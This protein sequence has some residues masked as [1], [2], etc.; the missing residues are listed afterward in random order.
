MK[1]YFR[2]RRSEMKYPNRVQ[3]LRQS[4]GLSRAEVAQQVGITPQALGLI[5][6]GRV[7]PLTHV[8]LGLAQALGTTVESLFQQPEAEQSTWRLFAPDL[9][10]ARV[11][12]RIRAVVGHVSGQPI[13]R[14][15]QHAAFGTPACAMAAPTSIQKA[16]VEWLGDPAQSF[17]TLFVSGCDPALSLVCGWMN[18]QSST[19]QAVHFHA[20]NRQSLAELAAGVTHIAAIH[21]TLEDLSGLLK[22]CEEPVVAIELARACM[23]WIVPHGNPK[24]WVVS[25]DF[26]DGEIRIVN[27][28]IGAGARLLID[29]ELARQ[30][31]NPKQVTGYDREVADHWQVA[32]AVPLGAAD[33]GVA[34][35]CV[36]TLHHVSFIPIRNEITML[37]IPRSYLRHPAVQSLCEVLQSDRFRSDLGAA[38]PY[39][40]EHTGQ[41]FVN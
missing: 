34:H 1:I 30:S 28:P 27:R 37:F 21:G 7:S 10:P 35:E 5:E 12:D 32:Q 26:G 4:T 23:G 13:V 33:V 31:L 9:D 19:C 20:T 22:Q 3:Q 17:T 40:V 25:R 29:T 39:D 38:G 41:L 14:S 15:L 6:Q 2:T 18:K 16:R 24:R 11:P 36:C 8:A